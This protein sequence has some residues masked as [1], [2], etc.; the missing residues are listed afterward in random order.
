[1]APPEPVDFTTELPFTAR[2]TTLARQLLRYHLLAAG[3][4][5]EL[6]ENAELVLHE[7]ISNCVDHGYPCPN[8]TLRLS[9]HVSAT[10]VDVTVTD[11][12]P[13]PRCPRCHS[14][15]FADAPGRAP[16]PGSAEITIIATTPAEDAPRGRGLLIVEGLS[17]RW[18]VTTTGDSTTVQATITA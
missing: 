9:W 3:S 16:V 12:G 18:E 5:R 6:A 4:S 8:D 14:A 13:H 17:D 1:M 7:L 11:H 10:R 2:S 15:G